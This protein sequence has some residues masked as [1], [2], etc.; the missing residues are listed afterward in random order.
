MTLTI[1]TKVYLMVATFLV[2]GIV[3]V[4]AAL[5][6][7]NSVNS[8]LT[9]ITQRNAPAVKNATGVE[10]HALR[11]ILDEKNYLLYEKG[12][13]RDRAMAQIN[14]IYR[15]LDLEADV[16]Q[17]YGDQ[18]LAR[19]VE[20]VR[21]VT[22]RY[23]ALYNEGVAAL[24]ANR[25]LAAKMDEAGEEVGAQAVAYAR[26][27]KAELRQAIEKGED[28]TQ[29]MTAVDI[30]TRIEAVALE[31]RMNE[32][33]YMLYRQRSYYTAIE[34]NIAQLMQYY[35]DLE[36]VST[37][38]KDLERI[39]IARQATA[40]YL[41]AAQNWVGNDDRLA[42]I[43]SEMNTIGLQVQ[44]TAMSAQDINWEAMNRNVDVSN[45]TVNSIRLTLLALI[46]VVGLVG[47]LAGLVF[48]QSIAMPLLHLSQGIERVARGDL[49]RPVPVTTRDEL[50]QLA[51]S[52][53]AMAGDLREA[54]E[55]LVRSERLAAIGEL[56]AGIG[57]ELRQ[58]L[59]GIS[60]AAYYLHSK[61]GEAD[62]R[63]RESVDIL[64]SE[65]A[66][67]DKIIADLLDFSRTRPPMLREADLNA[68]VKEVLARTEVP[69]GVEV[70]TALEKDLP[71]VMVDGDQVQQ[72]FLNLITNAVQAM[73]SSSS[74]ETPEGGRLE[75]R[76]ALCEV[77]PD[78]W[79]IELSFTDTGEGIPEENLPHIFEPLFTT[80]AKGIGLGLAVSQRLVEGHGGSI[81][82]H[83]E[84]GAGST[85]TVRLPLAP[86]GGFQ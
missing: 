53:N 69:E 10:R 82:V 41:T 26:D 14:E 86:G 36:K 25:Q 38:Q 9:T 50:G 43:L 27:K 56:A 59:G 5:W 45:A 77:E 30:V 80:R 19:K 2:V 12:E 4:G 46:A 67:A 60:N 58:P 52:F 70:V 21:Q 1:R 74:V 33:A 48:I 76:S 72:V 18:E 8:V 73:T 3:I 66:R 40:D 83:S 7:L 29:L 55:R 42:E 62:Q 44:D 84:V 23:Q 6:G 39:G 32:K 24:E 11:T 68:L 64:Q 78:T 71:P 85:F 31:T 13:I 65:V 28:V 63:V 57:H 54:R 20:A 51:R 17:Q 15:Y 35:D 79:S 37:S 61:L 34:V 81:E 49:S 75:V 22:T 16:A 47:L